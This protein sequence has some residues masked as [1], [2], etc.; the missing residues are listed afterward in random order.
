MYIIA[1]FRPYWPLINVGVHKFINWLSV[2]LETSK[3]F[4]LDL[5][6]DLLCTLLVPN[7]SPG[8]LIVSPERFSLFFYQTLQEIAETVAQI[9][10]WAMQS[11]HMPQFIVYYIMQLLA[12]D[13]LLVSLL[14][15]TFRFWCF[16]DRASQNDLSNW[17]T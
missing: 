4:A 8:P 2:V 6:N 13:I 12:V 17:A 11:S 5:I 3:H 1:T 15:T 16:A 7:S 9:M 14:N 10:Q